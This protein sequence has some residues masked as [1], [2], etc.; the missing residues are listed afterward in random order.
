[1]TSNAELTEPS[2]SQGSLPRA[3]VVCLPDIGALNF[4]IP[5]HRDRPQDNYSAEI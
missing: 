3:A 2:E 1:M 4:L 5:V